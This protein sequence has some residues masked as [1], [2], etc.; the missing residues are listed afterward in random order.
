MPASPA[1]ISQITQAAR[2]AT[3]EDGGVK[4]LSLGARELEIPS[5]LYDQADAGAENARQFTLIKISRNIF[6]LQVYEK[7]GL[8]KVGQTVTV[9]YPRFGLAGGKDF[10]ITG[11]AEQYGPGLTILTLWG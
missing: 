7:N 3:S 4:T 2:I 6:Q 1:R 8:F 10:M 11:L 5:A 9:T